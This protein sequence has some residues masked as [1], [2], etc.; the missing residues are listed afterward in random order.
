MTLITFAC[1]FGVRRTGTAWTSSEPAAGKTVSIFELE[2]TDLP[3]DVAVVLVEPAAAR[4][5][6]TTA[7]ANPAAATQAMKSRATRFMCS[8]RR[9]PQPPVSTDATEAASRG[10]WC[11]PPDWSRARR[12]R[13]AAG[14]AR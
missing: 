2:E 9:R 12:R 10:R 14:P 11:L 4:V 6:R 3:V 5:G 7:A 1:G 8:Q 13:R